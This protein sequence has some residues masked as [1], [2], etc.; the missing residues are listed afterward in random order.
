MEKR[1]EYL[2]EWNDM[3]RKELQECIVDINSEYKWAN[4]GDTGTSREMYNRLKKWLDTMHPLSAQSST[5]SASSASSTSGSAQAG[6]KR[7]ASS[8]SG[9]GN[10]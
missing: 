6:K 10:G 1:N 9:S 5:A 8:T 7:K 3:P 4:L 2:A